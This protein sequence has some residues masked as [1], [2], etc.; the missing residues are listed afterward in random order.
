MP[1][2]LDL[3]LLISLLLALAIGLGA[4]LAGLIISRLITPRKDYAMK[5][6]RFECANPA[7]GKARG[8]FMMQ[9]FGY[10]IIFLTVE[11]LMIYSFL[12]LLAGRVLFLNT[13]QLFAAIL[14]MLAPP[15]IFGLN[16]A[17]KL[18]LWRSA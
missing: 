14:L 4:G 13:V 15:L 16:S 1:A 5:K 2:L 9:Y 12:F 3:N 17:T 7:V 11:P 18:E 8:W 6:E 10:I